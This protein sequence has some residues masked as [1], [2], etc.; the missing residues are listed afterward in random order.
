MSEAKMTLILT[1]IILQKFFRIL[2]IYPRSEPY[3]PVGKTNR[4][5]VQGC[6]VPQ[7]CILHRYGKGLKI[8][9]NVLK[10]HQQSWTPVFNTFP[11]RYKQ[12]MVDD[13]YALS[14]EYAKV[15]KDVPVSMFPITVA[16]Q[17][18]YKAKNRFETS[19]RSFY[20]G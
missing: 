17:P 6:S 18:M 4:T 2:K 9:D 20:L 5:F 14:L 1:L 12:L 10:I 16:K 3:L 11:C 7:I 19:E 15:A 8:K 13:C